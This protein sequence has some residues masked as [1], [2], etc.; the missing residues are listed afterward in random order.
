MAIQRYSAIGS[1]GVPLDNGDGPKNDA[2]LRVLFDAY[3]IEGQE[4][5]EIDTLDITP[6][7]WDNPN[8]RYFMSRNS[9]TDPV[10]IDLMPRHKGSEAFMPLGQF[11]L[12]G[13]RR[14]V[15]PGIQKTVAIAGPSPRFR[16]MICIHE[17]IIAD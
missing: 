11:V 15:I 10:V 4:V 16:N 2:S 3:D 13:I 9:E 5:P 14:I 6:Y 1:F 17:A 7:Y 8:F 12:A